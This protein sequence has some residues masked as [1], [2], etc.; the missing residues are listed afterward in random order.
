MKNCRIYH[1]GIYA[2]A[3]GVIKNGLVYIQGDDSNLD[4]PKAMF[5][6]EEECE[7]GLIQFEVE[8]KWGFANIYTGE[9]RIDPVWDYASPFYSG[10]ARVSLGTKIE[11]CSDGQIMMQGGKYGYIDRNGKVVI[12]LEYDDVR[13]K[14]YDE[15]YFEVAKNG[16]WGTIDK[17]NS[18]IISLDWDSVERLYWENNFHH[19]I[20][21]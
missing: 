13:N 11:H 17:E 14:S 19:R 18:V 2:Y 8:G 9:I 5:M 16:K 15:N 20:C 10:Y 1:T 7:G 12:P 21:F 3:G 4:F 6:A